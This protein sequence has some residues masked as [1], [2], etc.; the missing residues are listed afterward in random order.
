MSIKK[1]PEQE[2]PRER[3]LAQG[4]AA[5]SDAELLAVILRTGSRAKDA[6]A[7]ARDLLSHFKHL[8]TLLHA[9]YEECAGV[10]GLGPAK[11]AQLQAVL[12]ISRRYLFEKI[13][14]NSAVKNAEMV[15][16]YLVMQLGGL[17]RETFCCLLLD[18]KY[19][20]LDFKTLFQGSLARAEVYVREVVQL[21][22]SRHAAAIIFA[23]N[24]PSGDS[25]P[26]EDDIQITKKLKMA[27]SLVD[28]VVLDH[29]VIGLNTA[30]SMAEL[31]L[32]LN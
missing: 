11:Y 17:K 26:S 4:S 7:L 16:E 14:F 2:R 23:H 9:R 31:G 3:L 32:I 21:G 13:H 24:H 27:L 19:H 15:K 10:I 18:T 20:I 8:K 30:V 12:E 6:V 28:I 22:L 29:M 5:L 25:T 1:W